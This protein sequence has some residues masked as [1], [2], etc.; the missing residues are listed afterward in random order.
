MMSQ[1]GEK[2]RVL[3][4]DDIAETRENL[5]KLLSFDADIEIVG[6]AAS[7][8]EGI[9]LARQ[10]RPHVI[11]M[12]INMPG[13]DGIA[14]TEKIMQELPA[15]QVVMLSVQGESGYLRSAMLAGA[16]D[17]LTKPP[18]GDELMST[19]RKVYAMGKARAAMIAPAPP[20]GSKRAPSA[21]A[22]PLRE[23]KII[24]VFSPK[25]GVGCTTVAVNLAVALQ[26]MVGSSRKVALVDTSLQFGDVGVMLNLQAS[27]SI[28]DLAPHIEELDSDLLN[29]VLT[30]HSSGLKVLLAPRRPEE[31]E[32]LLVSMSLDEGTVGNPAIRAILGL[33]REEFDIIVVDMWSWIDEIALTVFDTTTLIVLVAMPNI[34]AIK[35]ARLFLEVADQLN[36]PMDKIVLAVN[37]VDR[38]MGIRVQQIEQAMIPVAV[39][40]PL[41]EPVVLT[42]SNHG[43]P[44]VVRDQSRPVSQSIL[45]LAEH[46]QS[47]LAQLDEV[48]EEEEMVVA[49]GP[50]LLRLGRIFGDR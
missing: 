19:I 49:G 9:E 7:G 43:V 28:V 14:A 22:G 26:Q 40:I 10:F 18:S 23:G 11:L 37:G 24:A 1:A 31:A 8:P 16:R 41:D 12:D 44:F 34:P 48:E 2:I 15:I 13:M 47:L 45:Q 46:V 32:S 36:Y 20:D 30:P 17:F 4:V 38:R 33:M 21:G 29:S 42:A 35:S 25:G 27:R 6:A 50:S 39:Q 3:I 5:R